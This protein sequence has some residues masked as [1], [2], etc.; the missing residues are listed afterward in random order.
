M[1]KPIEAVMVGA[2]GRG[3]FAYGPYALQHPDQLRFTAVVEP[4]EVR[5][6]RFAAAHNI[7]PERQFQTWDALYAQGKIA[8]ALLNCTLDRMHVDS[9]LPALELGYDVLLEKPMLQDRCEYRDCR[10]GR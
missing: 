4:H 7:A 5:R 9:T 6:R 8:D 2:G 3:Y 10:A 1:S